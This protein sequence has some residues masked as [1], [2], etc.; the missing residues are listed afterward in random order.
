MA[1]RSSLWS[2]RVNVASL[3]RSP[4]VSSNELTSLGMAVE[5]SNFLIIPIKP[6]NSVWQESSRQAASS[7]PSQSR[8]SALN[9]WSALGFGEAV[10]PVIPFVPGNQLL[11]YATGLVLLACG[12]CIAV[13]KRRGGRQ[14]GWGS[15]F[16]WEPPT[17][18]FRPGKLWHSVLA[19]VANK[20]VQISIAIWIFH[21]YHLQTMMLLTRFGGSCLPWFT[22]HD[23]RM[24]APQAGCRS[25]TATGS[26]KFTF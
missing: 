11:A 6:Y 24:A 10:M 18:L 5:W 7:S 23:R 2:Q 20:V 3:G 1:R 15:S 9:T 26:S 19:W 8:P 4:T 12:R 14:S 16:Y 25:S 17:N 13:H 21:S 22:T